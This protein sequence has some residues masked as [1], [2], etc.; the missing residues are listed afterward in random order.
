[1]EKRCCG[2]MQLK[3][4]SPLCEHCG[5]NENIDNLP[6]QLSVNTVLKGR[7]RLG[8]VL[9]QG[10]FGITYIG[11]DLKENVP[12]AVKEYYPKSVVTR[13]TAA[14]PSV[15]CTDAAGREYFRQYRTQFLQ[16]ARLLEKFAE[17]PQIV[18][19]KTVFEENDTVYMAMEH[20]RGTDL[21]MYLRM[22][23][24]L[25]VQQTFHILSP[26]MAAL[27]RGHESGLVHKDIS[28]D[29]IMILPN[30][31]AKLLDFGAA[32]DVARQFQ[33][34]TTKTSLSAVKHGFAPVEQYQTNGNLGPWTDV[35]ALC[36]T[37]HYCLTGRIPKQALDR[38]SD[39]KLAWEAIPGL[40][41]GQIAALNKGMEPMPEDRFAN[42]RELYDALFPPTVAKLEEITDEKEPSVKQKK[43][44]KPPKPPKPPREKK[45]ADP[46]L[47]K[48]LLI[49]VAGL[50]VAAA[51]VALLMVPRGWKQE[52]GV[53]SYYR[54]G[55]PVTGMQTIDEHRYW[56][57]A[58]GAMITGWQEIGGAWYFFDEEGRM[59]T[60]T[61][62]L[63]GM[64][65]CFAED[66]A[67]RHR[68]RQ[69]KK[70][71]FSAHETEDKATFRKANGSP[72]SWTYR[73]LETPIYDC[74]SF[75]AEMKM[76]DY[77]S[78]NV[79]QWA[80]AYRDLKG[81]WHTVREGFGLNGEKAEL[82][83]RQEEG[84]SFDAYVWYCQSIGT[85]W[86]FERSYDLTQVQVM[87]HE[88]ES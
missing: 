38:I 49:A 10:G 72:Q 14:S 88:I 45:P 17:V 61:V 7:F 35:Y 25:T 69:L 3:T 78:G 76:V 30:G 59:T 62:E 84:I 47:T 87:E 66:G 54:D 31:Q 60:G 77:K 34:T 85:M 57:D 83:F 4:Q 37:I 21:R 39:K 32:Q 70:A 79:D 75:R 22:A 15:L 42:V 40:T 53:T 52:N 9:G 8:K 29:N 23:G 71:E 20:V 26:V 56:F 50:A 5:Y 46:A 48:K 63:G 73:E 13:D 68:I 81:Q 44:E 24:L 28:P 51:A 55:K 11:W 64:E 65:Y 82:E 27:S 12:V 36:A 43:P 74:V 33:G 86:N 67:F 41:P 58:D 16:E 1:M 80:F 19:V 6:H 2:C 18:H